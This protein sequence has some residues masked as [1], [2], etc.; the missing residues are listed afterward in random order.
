M[1]YAFA[2]SVFALVARPMSHRRH[3]RLRTNGR[4]LN[5]GLHRLSPHNQAEVGNANE[6]ENGELPQ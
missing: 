2:R 1:R 5:D 4:R 6:E 3:G